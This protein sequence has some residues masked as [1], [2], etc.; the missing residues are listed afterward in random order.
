VEWEILL[1]LSGRQWL[2]PAPTLVDSLYCGS[3]IL[4]F[5]A[6]AESVVS[7]TRPLDAL[8][9]RSFGVYLIHA[10]VLELVART[11][12]HVGP[13]LLGNQLLFQ[14]LL[15]AAG[16][17]VPLLLMAAIN[18]SPARPAYSYVFG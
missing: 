7:A 11:C 2:P 5:A 1:H 16:I 12:Y 17:G 4:T 18:R 6:Y 9:A 15:I 10:P 14:S 3:L 13:L 8:G